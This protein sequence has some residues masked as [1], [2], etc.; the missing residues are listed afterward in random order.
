MCARPLEPR[1]APKVV[2]AASLVLVLAV[3]LASAAI[4]L[5]EG[6]LGAWLPL[7]R[8]VHRFSASAATLGIAVLAWVAWRRGRRAH[9]A[10]LVLLTAFLSVLGAATGVA[11]P[12]PAQAANL[13]G[14]LALAALLA[15]FFGGRVHAPFMALVAVQALLGAW[16]SIFAAE[17]WTA[18]LFAH[19]LLGLALAG[20]AAWAAVHLAHPVARFAGLALAAAVPASGATAA[21]LGLPL[22][23]TLAHSAAVAT[24]VTAAAAARALGL[25]HIKGTPVRA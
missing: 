8:G 12:A 3:I 18:A 4:R 23:A 16:V 15:S 11:P 14:G 10:A 25:T 13:L 17:L 6:D 19:V 1:L 21:L 2:A 20:A 24:F 9:A 7:I 22:A 5:S